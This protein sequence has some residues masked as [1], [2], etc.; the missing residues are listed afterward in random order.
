MSFYIGVDG[1]GTKTAYALFDEHKTMLAQHTG[2]GSNHEGMGGG[3]PAA[4]KVLT[5]GVAALLEPLK[6]TVK[7]VTASLM[8]LAGMDHPYQ[9]E[10]MLKELT[11]R[12]FDRLRVVNDGFIVVKAGVGAGAGIGYNCGTGTCCNSIDDE[13]TLRQIGG[14]GTLT[15]DVGGGWWVASEAFR[16][17]YDDLVLGRFSSRITADLTKEYGI[18]DAGSWMAAVGKMGEEPFRRFLI[19]S[20]FAAAEAEDEGALEVV[21]QMALRGARFIAGH[22]KK[23][24]F[25]GAQVPVVLS[26][27]VHLK[28]QNG[29][30]ITRMQR[31]AEEMSGR[32]LRF[33]KL[34][35]PPVWGC[36]HWMLEQQ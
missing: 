19:G 14:L 21:E 4:A 11:A 30:Y 20:L 10:E 35:K 25:N 13:G 16:T 36:I 7:D 9:H 15:G 23:G 1:G 29:R 31:L 18:A 22:L 8:G 24:I 12:G 6:L 3:I 26:G 32:R 2:P 17:A 33:L 27:S 34:D 5:E 28:T